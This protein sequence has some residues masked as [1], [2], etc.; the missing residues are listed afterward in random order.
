MELRA[1]QVQSQEWRERC[2]PPEHRTAAMQ[3]MGVAEET[4][5]LCHAILKM[6]QG[7]RG[8]EYEHKVEAADA[9]GDI[10]IYLAG[11]CSSLDLDLDDCVHTAWAQV[12]NRDWSTY[13]ETGVADA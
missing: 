4:G 8:S 12:K 9:V 7:I 11:V 6:T 10:I 2:F 1:L 3:A 5:E 13:K